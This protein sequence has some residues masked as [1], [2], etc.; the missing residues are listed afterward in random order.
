MPL[1]LECKG[2]RLADIERVNGTVWTMGESWYRAK[3][4]PLNQA[5]DQA[6]ALRKMLKDAKAPSATV[7][8]LIVLPFIGRHEFERQLGEVALTPRLVFA[9]DLALPG[10]L[11]GSHS[12][13]RIQLAGEPKGETG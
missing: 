2:C 5:R 12:R 3:E 10:A 7:H 6:I 4:N 9:D 1:V 13:R 11:C 8:S